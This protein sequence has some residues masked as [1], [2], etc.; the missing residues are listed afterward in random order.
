MKCDWKSKMSSLLR[1]VL[2]FFCKKSKHERTAQPSATKQG[3]IAHISEVIIAL[4]SAIWVNS[5]TF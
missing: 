1:S 3:Y 5:M 2:T 4:I